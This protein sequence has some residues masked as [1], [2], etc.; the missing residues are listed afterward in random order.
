M[1]ALQPA[2]RSSSSMRRKQ[3]MKNGRLAYDSFLNRRRGIEATQHAVVPA[4]SVTEEATRRHVRSNQAAWGNIRG[5]IPRTRPSLRLSPTLLPEFYQQNVADTSSTFSSCYKN[6]VVDVTHKYN[7]LD[8]AITEQAKVDLFLTRYARTLKTK[9]RGESLA[10]AF[11]FPSRRMGDAISPTLYLCWTPAKGDVI[12]EELARDR[13]GWGLTVYGSLFREVREAMLRPAVS[14]N[15]VGSGMEAEVGG[16]DTSELNLG[17]ESAVEGFGETCCPDLFWNLVHGAQMAEHASTSSKETTAD[18]TRPSL[19][20]CLVRGEANS[21]RRLGRRRSCEGFRGSKMHLDPAVVLS[22]FLFKTSTRVRVGY[23]SCTQ[24]R[25]FHITSAG[26]DPHLRNFSLQRIGQFA[27]MNKSFFRVLRQNAVCLSSSV[28]DLALRKQ[29]IKQEVA[30]IATDPGVD[31][32][33][34]NAVSLEYRRSVHFALQTAKG[35]TLPRR[36]SSR[37][38]RGQSVM[39]KGNIIPVANCI[40]PPVLLSSILDF[41]ELSP[42][43]I[44]SASSLAGKSRGSGSSH[45]NDSSLPAET[46]SGWSKWFNGGSGSCLDSLPKETE[47]ASLDL[48]RGQGRGNHAVVGSASTKVKEPSDTTKKGLL[49]RLGMSNFFSMFS[50]ADAGK[51]KDSQEAASTKI[52]ST[53]CGEGQEAIGESKICDQNSAAGSFDIGVSEEEVGASEGAQVRAQAAGTSAQSR[54]YNAVDSEIEDEAKRLEKEIAELE[55]M[56]V[57]EEKIPKSKGGKQREAKPE[58]T[59]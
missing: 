57:Q 29:I 43:N 5:N 42:A 52:S 31:P 23:T 48:G 41:R 28:S 34:S 25:T 44:S 47:E 6:H 12:A 8:K 11:E 56:L 22:R 54:E 26:G 20:V 45:E 10:L 13:Q 14:R 32:R 3:Q 16:K 24:R 35:T 33:S 15:E 21:R 30:G 7:R 59:I 50:S 1:S 2:S 51:T 58:E 17:A 36:R 9:L 46:G 37:S 40:R 49:S 39:K 38:T 27:R 4:C 18:A 19:R 53:V 55:K